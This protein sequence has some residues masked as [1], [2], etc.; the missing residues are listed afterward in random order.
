VAL[1]RLPPATSGQIRLDERGAGRQKHQGLQT[2][3]LSIGIEPSM[4][5]PGS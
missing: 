1:N 4:L 3:D 2:A 5:T